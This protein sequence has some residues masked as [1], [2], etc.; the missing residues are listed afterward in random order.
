ML[1]LNLSNCISV[2]IAFIDYF[3]NYSLSGARQVKN[4]QKKKNIRDYNFF[5]MLTRPARPCISINWINE[6]AIL[7]QEKFL[8]QDE[9][10]DTLNRIK[11]GKERGAQT[12]HL[13]SRKDL[14]GF[15]YK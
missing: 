8:L 7:A 11:K 1:V 10:R 3:F 5:L 2:I 12:F 9:E 13:F 15:I 4:M 14:E 6:R